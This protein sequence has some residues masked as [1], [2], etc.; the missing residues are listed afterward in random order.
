MPSK[1]L[2]LL[3]QVTHRACALTDVWQRYIRHNGMR[4]VGCC[5]TASSIAAAQ[6]SRL[7]RHR[8]SSDQNVLDPTHPCTVAARWQRRVRNCTRMIVAASNNEP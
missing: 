4:I 8:M 5:S 2:D 7:A 3:D 6:A 1:R